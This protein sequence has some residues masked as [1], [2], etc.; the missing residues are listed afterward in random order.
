[1][2]T[3]SWTH[4][5]SQSRPFGDLRT[6]TGCSSCYTTGI[7]GS[8]A[9]PRSWITGEVVLEGRAAGTHEYIDY[10]LSIFRWDRVAQYPE[11]EPL[12]LSQVL[13]DLILAG[14]LAYVTEGARFDDVGTPEAWRETNARWGRPGCPGQR[15]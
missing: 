10:G 8:R 7:A 15:F 12:D 4:R 6:P 2:A 11:G 14:R 9:T 1:M 5:W 3:P 13:N